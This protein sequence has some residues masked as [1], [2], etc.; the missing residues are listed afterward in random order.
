[1]EKFYDDL[2][3]LKDKFSLKDFFSF[4]YRNVEFIC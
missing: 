4:Y 3:Y 2:G 1:M